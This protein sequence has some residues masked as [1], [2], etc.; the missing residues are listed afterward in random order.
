MAA[1]YWAST[2]RQH[3]V[4]SRENLRAIRQGLESEDSDLTK[5]YPTVDWRLLSIY[6]N[7]R[8]RASRGERGKG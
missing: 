3:W 1:N 6:F 8:M 2:Q 7:Q 5:Q 4:Y